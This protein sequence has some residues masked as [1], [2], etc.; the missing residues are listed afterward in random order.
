MNNC[1]FFTRKP[2]PKFCALTANRGSTS[3]LTNSSKKEDHNL[4]S[5][6][7]YH[8]LHSP[9]TKQTELSIYSATLVNITN[10]GLSKTKSTTTVSRHTGKK[11]PTQT[12]DSKYCKKPKSTLP[13]NLQPQFETCKNTVNHSPIR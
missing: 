12:K 2:T 9:P 10:K 5:Q 8:Q 13:L 4:L 1:M 7:S 3:Q 6:K 11:P